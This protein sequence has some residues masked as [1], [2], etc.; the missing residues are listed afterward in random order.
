MKVQILRDGAALTLTADSGGLLKNVVNALSDYTKGC[1]A[2]SYRARANGQAQYAGDLIRNAE[3]I[4]EVLTF[5]LGGD[6]TDEE[7]K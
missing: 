7:K 3:H 4:N 2:R 5:L 1:Y 6:S